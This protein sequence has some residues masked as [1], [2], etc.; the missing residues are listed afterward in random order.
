MILGP[1]GR[2]VVS[3]RPA[4]DRY[5][6]GPPPSSYFRGERERVGEVAA[7]EESI[8]NVWRA[9][10]LL[11]GRRFGAKARYS[12]TEA[13]VHRS[14]CKCGQCHDVGSI[15]GMLGDGLISKTQLDRINRY[16]VEPVDEDLSD[17]GVFC[18]LIRP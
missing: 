5:V 12:F 3:S 15:E 8:E 9:R 6:G 17:E 16:R 4:I 13:R 7:D 10:L 11:F 1:N 14:F 18:R 2:P